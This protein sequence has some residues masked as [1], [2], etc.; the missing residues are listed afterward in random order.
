VATFIPEWI[1][2]SAREVRIARVLNEL[3]DFH[4]VRRALRNDSGAVDFFIQHR[5]KGWFAVSIEDASFTDIDPT[6]LIASAGQSRF[7]ARLSELQKLGADFKIAPH[8]IPSLVLLW[9]CSIEEVAVLTHTYFAKHGI[10]LVAKTR[11]IELG[12]KLIGLN[13]APVSRDV[14]HGLF[15]AYFPEAAIPAACTLR[16]SF[17]RDNSATLEPTYLDTQ[18]EWAAKLD[19]EW[20]PE[21][22]RAASDFSVRLINGV[23]GS[24]KTLIAVN[25]ARLLAELFP[26]QRILL[27]IHN[28]P[29]VADLN[30]RLHRAHGGLPS[31]VDI[32][33]FS[34]WAN[35]QWFAVFGQWPRLPT[36][37]EPVRRLVKR[38]R[39]PLT[40][41]AA[42]DAQLIDELNFINDNLLRD[43]ASY[44]AA[45]RAGRGFALRSKDRSLVWSLYLN[46]TAALSKSRMHLW[47]AVPSVLSSQ[48]QLHGRLQKYQH[49][50]VDEAQFFSP[51]ALQLVK[52]SLLN[53]GQL[54]LCA[55][56][57]QGFMKS[58]MS[59]KSAG[60]EVVGR[61]KKLRK[62]YRTTRAILEAATG[63]LRLIGAPSGTDSDD[64]LV[65]DFD[66]MEAGEPPLLLYVDSPH[67]GIERLANELAAMY[68]S[69][70]ARGTQGLPLAATLVIYGDNVP[71]RPLYERLAKYCDH[72]VWWFNEDS[73]KKLPPQG[74]GKDYLR[75]ANVDTATGLEAAVVFLVGAE[76]L[77]LDPV[78]PEMAVD[79]LAASIEERA[80]K[81]YMAMT[82]AGQRLVVISSKPLPRELEKLFDKR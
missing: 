37:P 29:I 64:F 55:D 63:V 48:P 82:R 53:H 59:W 39:P 14:E 49:I 16:R 7:E 33:T 2:V 4:V 18:Q 73:Q 51:S 69:Q 46:V 27:I 31:T 74:Y 68:D 35:A 24:G 61:T 52:V 65:P 79:E 56:P 41:L 3:D 9:N 25:R 1:K 81:L 5:Y 15:S 76:H 80:R 44:H 70:G 72:H 34:S 32:R 6:Q 28:T 57:N 58:R 40:E 75:M 78:M 19:L 11:F 13:L 50:L 23:A 42:R 71:K 21:A 22:T 38:L 10:R 77:L 36:S 66:A 17:H 30:E 60:I 43:E 12:A 62:S 20:P 67:D 54:F 26:A 47:S 45:N 8:P